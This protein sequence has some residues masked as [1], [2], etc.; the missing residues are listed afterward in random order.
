MTNNIIRGNSL[1]DTRPASPERRRIGIRVAPGVLR[2]VV[3]QNEIRG[4][5]R[6]LIDE[7][8]AG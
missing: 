6:D 8:A 3:E 7:R 1:V 4:M 2:P 5:D